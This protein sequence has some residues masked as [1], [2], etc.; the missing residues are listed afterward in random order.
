MQV[1]VAVPTHSGFTVECNRHVFIAVV[2]KI[3]EHV[4]ARGGDLVENVGG[5]AVIPLAQFVPLSIGIDQD[6]ET[7]V[8]AGAVG[9]IGIAIAGEGKVE[10]QGRT[11]GKCDI[12]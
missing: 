3:D 6:N 1:V 12:R 4:L 9:G 10:S 7:V 8:F 11:R 5:T 2:R